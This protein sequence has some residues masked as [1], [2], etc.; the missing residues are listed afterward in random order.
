MHNKSC[1]ITEICT[2]AK[3]GNRIYCFGAGKALTRTLELNKKYHLEKYISYIVDNSSE[4]IGQEISIGGQRIEIID[5]VRLSNM[6]QRGDFILITSIYEDQIVAQLEG[7]SEFKDI[8]YCG[9]RVANGLQYDMER[10]Q[11][12]I[13]EKLHLYDE[14]K[15]PK[16]IHYCWFGRKPIPKQYQKWMDSWKKYCPDYEII[17]WNE[18]NF[19][20]TQNDY[21]KQAY[22]S[23]KWAFV[24]DFVRVDVVEKFGGVYLDTDVELVRNIDELLMNDAF[25]GFESI[26]YVAF[27]LGFGAVKGHPIIKKLRDDY[28]D[29]RFIMEDGSLNLKP[30]PQYQTELLKSYALQ[31]NGEFQILDGITILPEIVLSGKSYA[32]KRII[33]DLSNTYAI[34]HFAGSWL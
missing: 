3:N 11:I 25:C 18:D 6:I 9:Y 21:L 15:I 10:E 30:C 8:E 31:T 27:G 7:I 12:P 5:V 26:D 1:S 22:E 24:S 29:R 4:K 20:V 14:I 34:H 2:R 32:S 13:P 19:D 28:M 16:V 23:E 33:S 17:E